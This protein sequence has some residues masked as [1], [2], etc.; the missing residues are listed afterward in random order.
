MARRMTAGDI[1]KEALALQGLPVP[2]AVAS[3]TND[4]TCRQMWAQLR[5]QGRRLCK[6]TR[7][8][9]WQVLTREWQLPTVPGTTKYQL[10]ADFDSFK[11][12]TGW[13]A[14]SRLPL[15]GPATDTQWQTLKARAL[16]S[17]TLGV[18]YRIA[19]DQFEIQSSPSVAQTL[20]ILY[21]SRNWVRTV[22]STPAAPVYIDA[23]AEDG[24]VVL[25]DPEMMVAA[26]Q[27]GFMVAKGFD[28]S[29]IAATL[30]G[31]IEAAI[32]ADTDAPMLQI[33][34]TVGYPFLNT[35]FN[36]PDTGYG[37]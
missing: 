19:E 3:N 8:Y 20:S 4:V 11:D 13:N 29:V 24:D 34:H 21:T 33:A 36:T 27:M 12:S 14:T 10:P 1:V 2:Q 18:V 28:T 16:G 30:E 17:S 35:Q 15:L 6:P 9:R 25:F 32:D 26:V 23:P 5:T 31:L 37:G 22:S 7:T